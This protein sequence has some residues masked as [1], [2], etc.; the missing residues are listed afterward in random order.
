MEYISSAG[1]AWLARH[2]LN[3]DRMIDSWKQGR[4]VTPQPSWID[5]QLD[6]EAHPKPGCDIRFQNDL[7]RT[8]QYLDRISYRELGT[9]HAKLKIDRLQLPETVLESVGR[10]KP[11]PFGSILIIPRGKASPAKRFVKSYGSSIGR[12]IWSNC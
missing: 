10:L 5:S 4:P 7:W 1:V 12:A 2:G 6:P 9:R 8:H 3:I 11:K